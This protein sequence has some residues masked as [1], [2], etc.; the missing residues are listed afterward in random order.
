MM[1]NKE[2]AMRMSA[3]YILILTFFFLV[4]VGIGTSANAQVGRDNLFCPDINHQD[5]MVNIQITTLEDN[6]AKFT[7]GMI[8]V[9]KGIGNATGGL[10][11]MA[12][13][14][15]ST[16][17]TTLAPT[18]EIGTQLV[19]WWSRADN[20][21]THLQV[22]NHAE[23]TGPHTSEGLNVHVHIFS[24]N[25]IEVIDFCDTYT[26]LDTHLYD[27][28]NLV[29]NSG[30]P[31][32]TASLAGKEGIIIVTPVNMCS[33]AISE[34]QAID[35]N[36]LSGNLIISDTLGATMGGEPLGYSYGTNMYAR[37]AICSAPRC[38]GILDG[39]ANA[40]FDTILPEVVYG[41]FNTDTTDVGSDAVVMS[42]YDD[43]GPPYLPRMTLSNFLVSIVDNNEIQNSCGEAQACFLRLGA[44]AD[45]PARQ[46]F[47]LP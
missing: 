6:P 12:T 25:C 3:K 19:S 37:R 2:R 46:D 43:Y 1:K 13:S 30:L 8:G 38:T 9:F 35:H 22:T 14:G 33:G 27:L 15:A 10:D 42:F 11:W 23:G 5:G 26:P 24:S 40:R 4:T 34:S 47:T 39:S 45:L 36:F 20:R 21:N 32:N 17:G 31:V 7:A 29:T 16:T 28:S 44:N 18:N 41:L